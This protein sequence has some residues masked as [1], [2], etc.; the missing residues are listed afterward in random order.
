MSFYHNIF[1]SQYIFITIYFYH[2]IVSKCLVWI[3]PKCVSLLGKWVCG[4]FNSWKWMRWWKLIYFEQDNLKQLSF[5]IKIREKKSSWRNI[6][7][8]HNINILR[9]E[10]ICIVIQFWMK[11]TSFKNL[12]RFSC[13]SWKH[14]PT[15]FLLNKKLLF[16]VVDS[17]TF[18]KI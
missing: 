17:H 8:H 15:F 4:S 1:L 9:C 5:A 16:I 3:R 13:H 7:V 10:N 2:N 11:K 12:G 14:F 6:I 18:A